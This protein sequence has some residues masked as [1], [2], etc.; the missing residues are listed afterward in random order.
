MVRRA[1]HYS[2]EPGRLARRET[3]RLQRRRRRLLGAAAVGFCAA[4]AATIGFFV[5]GP[6]GRG[7]AGAAPPSFAGGKLRAS[8]P[9]RRSPKPL[10]HHSAAIPILMYHVLEAAKPG[11][12]YPE[13]W[14]SSADFAAQM[15]WLARH[16]YHAVTLRQAYGYWNAGKRLPAHPVVLTF[17]DGYRSVYTVGLPVLRRYGWA[18][19]LDLAVEHEW[20]DLPPRFV[21]Q[22]IDAG[23]ELDSHTLTHVD[24]TAVGHTQLVKE[25]AGSRALLRRQYHQP[26]AFFCYPSGRYD[27]LVL[28]EVRRAGYLGATT[29]NFGVASPAQGYFTLDRIRINASDGLAGFVAKLRSTAR[30]SVRA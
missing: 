25:I 8:K 30:V 2:V 9:K 28:A 12:P 23:W 15:R 24:L 16:G 19:V 5:A 3:A 4:L 17:D 7:S 14:V 22:L 11:A 10:K 1:Y 27:D 26:V 21:W 20:S 6:S 18:G 13:L 29:E